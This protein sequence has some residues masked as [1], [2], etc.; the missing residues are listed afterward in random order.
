MTDL[1][2]GIAGLAALVGTWSGRGTGEYPTIAPFG[3]AEDITIGHVGKPFL[4]YAQ[5]T[6][7]DDG[8]PLHTET[9]YFRTPE[10]GRI[11]LLLSQPSGIT[12]I[13][14]GTVTG[15]GRALVIEV[16][17]THVGL[18]SSAK[19]V[20]E[21]KRSFRL[22]GDDLTYTLAMAAVGQPLTHHLTATLHRVS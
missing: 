8:L 13:D 4:T 11:E 2:P 9:G 12:E 22:D 21:V 18:T 3:Y 16:R 14:E 17:S 1:H 20:L 7:S 5:R 19:E 10:P 6:R 15:S